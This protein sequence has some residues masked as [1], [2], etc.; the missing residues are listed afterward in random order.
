VNIPILASGG[1]V[2]INDDFEAILL[3]PID[4]IGQV[5]TLALQVRLTWTNI[6]GPIADGDANMIQSINRHELGPKVAGTQPHAPCRGNH[7]KVILGNPTV[8]MVGQ[9][10]ESDVGVLV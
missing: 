5:G 7:C 4:S 8:P 10:C 2:E 1:P 9:C 3:C 6:V